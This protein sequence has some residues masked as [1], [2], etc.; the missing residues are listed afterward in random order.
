MKIW[1]SKIFLKVFRVDHEEI[2]YF[3]NIFSNTH[4]LIK[5]YKI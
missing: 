5:H 1:K 3:M 2:E 4:T